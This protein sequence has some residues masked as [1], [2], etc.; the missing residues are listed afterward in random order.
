MLSYDDT[1]ASVLHMVPV[2]LSLLLPL[3]GLGPVG[4]VLGGERGRMR[5]PGFKKVVCVGSALA[6][7]ALGVVT[8]GMELQAGELG[9]WGD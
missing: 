5:G 9:S 8:G 4:G 1:T 2:A 3:V 7:A 6:C